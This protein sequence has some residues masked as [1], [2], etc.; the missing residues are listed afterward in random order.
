MNQFKKLSTQFRNM[1]LVKCIDVAA[2]GGKDPSFVRSWVRQD[3]DPLQ[4]IRIGGVLWTTLPETNRFLESR[5]LIEAPLS[6]GYFKP[7]ITD[8]ERSEVK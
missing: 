3:K 4:S 1:Q 7:A 8:V 2:A 5:G 6:M